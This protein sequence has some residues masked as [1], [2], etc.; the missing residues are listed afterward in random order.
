MILCTLLLLFCIPSEVYAGI[1]PG[2]G[3]GSGGGGSGGKRDEHP[4]YT[5]YTPKVTLIHNINAMAA[6][7]PSAEN[8]S[9]YYIPTLSDLPFS[10]KD[11]IQTRASSRFAIVYD[12][13]Y[14]TE[15]QLTAGS[16]TV[17]GSDRV[18]YSSQAVST[19]NVSN[20]ALK[21]IGYDLLLVDDDYTV[22]KVGSDINYK[23]KSTIAGTTALTAEQA[24][25]DIYKALGKF[26]YKV[27]VAFMRD[28]DWTTNSSPILSELSVLT[29]QS[30][31]NGLNIDESYTA[32]AVSRTKSNLYW[33]RFL[34]DGV[35]SGTD[36]NIGNGSMSVH[37][38]LTCNSGSYISYMEFLR[39]LV[40]LM[41]LYGEE[42]LDD[43]TYQ[44][45]IRN[46]ASQLGSV[47]QR[48]EEERTI[49]Y[50]LVAKGILD[51]ESLGDVDWEGNTYL[52]K[53][54]NNYLCPEQGNTIIDIL[55]RVAN[56]D[57]RLEVN[58]EPPEMD[59][60][61]ARAGYGVSTFE[62]NPNMVN[63][64]EQ[65]TDFSTYY[66]YLI[67]KAPINTYRAK[68]KVT[69]NETAD[70]GIID[71]TKYD[72][73]NNMR[74]SYGGVEYEPLP[75]TATEEQLKRAAEGTLT[76]LREKTENGKK[77]NYNAPVGRYLYYGIKKIDGKSYYHFK[78]SPDVAKQSDLSFRY[79]SNPQ[80]EVLVKDIGT[81]TLPTSDRGGVYNLVDGRYVQHYFANKNFDD[82]FVDSETKVTTP[83]GSDY[84]TITFYVKN[85]M[86]KKNKLSAYSSGDDN[87][88][89]WTRILN[90]NGSVHY[91]E[92]I[93]L[94]K[95]SA[96]NKGE[97][98]T[99]IVVQ[100][101][102]S[103]D[104][105]SRVQIITKNKTGIYESKFFRDRVDGKDYSIQGYYRASDNSLMVSYN[106]LVNKGLASGLTEVTDNVYVL[107][108]GT[109]S[110]NV[111]IYTGNGDDH[112][113]QYVIVGDTMYPNISD[114][115]IVKADGDT[116]INYRACIGWG[117]DFAFISEGKDA[118]VINFGEYGVN[119][120]KMQN[121]E[122]KPITTFFPT[123][124]TKLMYTDLTTDGGDNAD[125]MD[126][127]GF[128]LVGSY[129]L[130]PYLVVVDEESSEDRL[131]V[132][133][134][135]NVIDSNGD[136]HRIKK[137]DNKEVLRS[138][139]E[140]TGIKMTSQRGY[141]LK[142]YVLYKND[143]SDLNPKGLTYAKTTGH[144]P[145]GDKVI[146]MGWIWEPPE[147]A[148]VRD[149]LNDYVK[150]VDTDEGI[151]LPIFCYKPL[152]TS[153]PKYYDANV[154]LASDG[155]GDFL[156]IGYMPA[157]VGTA[158]SAKEEKYCTITR[159]GGYS[160]SKDAGES[161][162]DYELS[163]APTNIFAQLKGMGK[164]KVGEITA[165]TIYFGS[166]KC[167]VR[168]DKVLLS[169]RTTNF[170]S[171]SDAVCT[172]LSNGNSSVYVVTEAK[173][174]LGEILKEIDTKISYALDDPENLVDWGQ[175]KFGR[176]IMNLDAWSTVALIFILNILP[177]VALLLFFALMLLSLI[178][179]WTPWR[180]FCNRWFDIYS[181]LSLGHINVDSVNT[182]RLCF[183][184]LF[185][186]AI[187]IVIMDGHII[188]LMVFVA[189][190]FIEIYQ[191]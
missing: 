73:V 108:A 45:C 177:R 125:D 36:E 182:K 35:M 127:E 152:S 121:Q 189:K 170:K 101:S 56:K 111:T 185:C 9:V 25:M 106:Y 109:M 122:A 28:K 15:A 165:G 18:S 187:F 88:Y 102:T 38:Q 62:I 84:T 110:T 3:T 149:A 184:S 47:S 40:A 33:N 171:D 22:N 27:D 146:N 44:M 147:Y 99:N 103:R 55:A 79:S 135:N 1:I 34:K 6:Q 78:I 141:V 139:E 75:V 10:M 132:W 155:S 142:E 4:P 181:F 94:L 93:D 46:Y 14:D 26:E 136:K 105:Y 53:E 2:E 117:G 179:D 13:C 19:G 143:G 172:Y 168:N 161:T 123:A 115:L 97:N 131:Y 156:S 68:I 87:I 124:S 95:D 134:R 151:A 80:G 23:N 90:D 17:N 107:T 178:K 120:L 148:D 175:Y 137:E 174:N 64:S 119:G 41:N 5:V 130:S 173:T 30:G 58:T 126:Y 133:H 60:A 86:L 66:D 70:E 29:S 153:R 113:G 158:D 39:V 67:E 43:T 188:N 57:Q 20:P 169:G 42:S 82:S 24:I 191:R 85:N 72:A 180:R 167:T 183:I 157:Y 145:S 71:K 7:N 104:D 12:E 51:P 190:F 21:A 65:L 129:A 186:S 140:K 100:Q 160:F 61:L 48:S 163:T 54:Y 76:I 81:F 69:T 128:N 89:L 59:E 52:L 114:T 49:I 116:Y 154:N 98:Y 37:T 92:L 77:I 144:T 32:V 162:K 112:E 11:Y 138:F 50:Y 8:D 83:L 96:P 91:N 118:V 16:E 63:Y 74:I 164:K 159:S 166:S 31:T 176:L 150:S